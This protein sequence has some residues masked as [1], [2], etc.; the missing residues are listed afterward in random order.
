MQGISPDFYYLMEHDFEE[1]NRRMNERDKV[2]Q[3]ITKQRE[4]RM[5][6]YFDI[7]HRIPAKRSELPSEALEATDILI[8]AGKFTEQK[9]L[10]GDSLIY[11]NETRNTQG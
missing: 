4:G 6:P 9:Q 7:F 1:V 8:Q 3:D 10:D 5:R 11:L 2:L